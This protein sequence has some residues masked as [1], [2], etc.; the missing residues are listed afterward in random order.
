MIL[1]PTKIQFASLVPHVYPVAASGLLIHHAIVQTSIATQ[2]LSTFLLDSI[3]SGDPS[4]KWRHWLQVLVGFVQLYMFLYRIHKPNWS[5]RKWAGKTM[6][7][8]FFF[9]HWITRAHGYAI[10]QLVQVRRKDVRAIAP[11]SIDR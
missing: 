4:F 3:I 2:L 9:I 8:L 6:L 11:L 10:T 7:Y 5:Q 1:V